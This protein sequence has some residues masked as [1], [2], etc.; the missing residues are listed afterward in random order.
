M[1]GNSN[2]MGRQSQQK[3]EAILDHDPSSIVSYQSRCTI[4]AN[5]I[6]V[7]DLAYLKG[8]T[9]DLRPLM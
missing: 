5:I 6:Y 7:P 4:R 9:T 2:T 8:N 3:F 1:Q